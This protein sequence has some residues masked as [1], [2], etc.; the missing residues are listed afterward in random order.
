MVIGL[1]VC[2][3][4]A[5]DWLKSPRHSQHFPSVSIENLYLDDYSSTVSLIWTISDLYLPGLGHYVRV[6]FCAD[7]VGRSG[8]VY[9]KPNA[10]CCGVSACILM[11]SIL[12][13]L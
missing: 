7:C 1:I 4:D 3:C 11:I 9:G 2:P 12:Q 13:T 8:G 5:L 10:E 6:E